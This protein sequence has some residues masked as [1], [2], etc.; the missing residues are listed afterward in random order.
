MEIDLN[1][2]DYEIQHRKIN[3]MEGTKYLVNLLMTG[4]HG[5]NDLKWPQSEIEWLRVPR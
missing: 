1:K 2:S 4:K 3:G 5:R